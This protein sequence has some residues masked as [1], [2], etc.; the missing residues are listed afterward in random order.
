MVSANGEPI[1]AGVAGCDLS[2]A[3]LAAAKTRARRAVSL[4]VAGEGLQCQYHTYE[5]IMVN[6]RDLGRGTV[7][8]DYASGLA[9]WERTVW[10]DLGYLPG[11]PLSGVKGRYLGADTIRRA[12]LGAR[13]VNG[14]RRE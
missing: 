6:P 4:L 8:V 3:Q 1:R 9:C 12:L 2:E 11:F 7:H 5:A 13:L 14:H 10:D